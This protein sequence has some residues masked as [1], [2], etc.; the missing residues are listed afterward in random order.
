MKITNKHKVKL[1]EMFTKG[2][3]YYFNKSIRL[4]DFVKMLVYKTVEILEESKVRSLPEHNKYFA[5][6]EAMASNLPEWACAAIDVNPQN[7]DKGFIHSINKAHYG[8]SSIA[9]DKLNQEEFHI[10]HCE[11]RMWISSFFFKCPEKQLDEILDNYKKEEK[12]YEE[13]FND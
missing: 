1:S 7:I 8:I 4:E 10:F 6:C 2:L 9:F 12:Q 3:N 5:L 13:T 11:I